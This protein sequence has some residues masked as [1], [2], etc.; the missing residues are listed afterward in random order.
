MMILL[1]SWLVVSVQYVLGGPEI[2]EIIREATFPKSRLCKI[3][4][5]GDLFGH[6]NVV[7]VPGS[8]FISWLK[9]GRKRTRVLEGHD[10]VLVLEV[11]YMVGKNTLVGNRL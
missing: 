9:D 1:A 7:P 8:A 5:I 4:N 2:V 6:S 10:D 11:L 3:S